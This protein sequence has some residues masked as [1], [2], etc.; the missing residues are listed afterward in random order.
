MSKDT[1]KQIPLG[2]I[3]VVANP[4]TTF[5][6]DK[7]ASLAESIRTDGLV[8]P[9]LVRPNGT[10]R[11]PYDLVAG[12]RR[13]RAHRLIKAKTI[14]ATVREMTEADAHRIRLVENLHREDLH[15]LEEGAAF[16]ALIDSDDGYTAERLAEECGR[17]TGYVYQRI[18]LT[19]LIPDAVTAYAKEEITSGHALLIARLG[20]EPQ[21]AALEWATTEDWN[22]NLPTV[23]DLR[24][25]IQ[26]SLMKLADAAFDTTDAEL[27]PPA[28]PCAMCEKRTGAEPGLWPE[29]DDGD[30]CTD[31]ICFTLKMAAHI[32]R[33]VEAGA[34][35]LK[36]Y[37]HAPDT[38]GLVGSQYERVSGEKACK[39][40]ERGIVVVLQSHEAG[41]IV[42]ICRSKECKKHIRTGR[43]VKT[44][45]DRE[46]ERDDKERVR[47][48]VEVAGIL[49][50]RIVAKTDVGLPVADLR[51]F[52]PLLF[53]EL[54]SEPRKRMCKALGVEPVEVKYS[55]GGT[56]KSHLPAL[57]AWADTASRSDLIGAMWA[58][59]LDGP[60]EQA[61][62]QYGSDS[63]L[64][65]IRDISKRFGLRPNTVITA[66]RKS[67]ERRLPEDNLKG[68]G[69][70]ADS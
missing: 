48:R 66:V 53:A 33:E 6:E 17:S 39:F 63:S 51:R 30:Q 9:I 67:A 22:G 13:F 32:K 49:R 38:E 64:D 2:E 35:A 45:A 70:N 14:S 37:H 50:D 34:V 69:K 46:R 18:K 5:D 12:E 56:G 68:K 41:E 57:E 20:D 21:A 40:T 1:I 61:R 7:I 23:R 3:R 36:S 43:Y 29:I 59:V 10:K 26:R 16:K 19:R 42:W 27:N 62:Y 11:T 28:G 8:Q 15:P 25:W 54:G 4:R 52:V 55:W 24:N 60:V 58:A 44:E 65:R 47:R 31:S